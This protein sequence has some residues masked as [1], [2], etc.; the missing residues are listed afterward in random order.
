M[1]NI[2]ELLSSLEIQIPED[3]KTAFESAFNENY[4]TIAE[5]EKLRASRDN[6]KSQ[7]D[8]AQNALIEFEGFDVKVLQGKITQL[9]NDLAAKETEYQNKLS[10]MEFNA[11]LD[12]A[13]TASGAK[14]A[15]AVK[16]L[17]DIENLKSSKNQ[18][19]DIKKA[20]ETVKSENDYMFVSNE[21]IKNPV[22]DTGNPPLS[23]D[24][25]AAMR[26]AMG[27]PAEQK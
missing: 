19:E 13:I 6:Y 22:K 14:N 8:N 20:L 25:M 2:F 16:A 10:D 7:L 17:L 21:P 23:G 3:K 24:P 26:A 27:L 4:K 15:K 18:A 12:N 1:K 9:T 5:V 11:S